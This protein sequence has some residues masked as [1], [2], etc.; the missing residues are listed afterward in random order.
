MIHQN[1]R[2]ISY[3][4]FQKDTTPKVSI[5]ESTCNNILCTN[6]ITTKDPIHIKSTSISTP[7]HKDVDNN[8]PEIIPFDMD[9]LN[10]IDT[11]HDKMDDAQ[12]KNMHINIEL[13]YHIYMSLDP[14]EDAIDIDIET[15]GDHNT[16]SLIITNNKEIGN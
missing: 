14:F 4:T 6:Q 7:I 15:R 16:L 12:I 5:T 2:P 10:E 11:H 9:E 1:F 8:L 3:Q 13:P